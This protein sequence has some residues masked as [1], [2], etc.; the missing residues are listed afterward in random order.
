MKYKTC[1]LFNNTEKMLLP[2]RA[3]SAIYYASNKRDPQTIR[4]MVVMKDIVDGD[5]LMHS[6]Q[7]AM[8]RY[9][10]Y[11]IAVVEN[12]GR[13]INVKNNRP[14]VVKHTDKPAN[15]GSEEVNYHMIA[16]SYREKNIYL[17]ASHG[18]LDG[19]SM[20][21]VLKTVILLYCN[22]KYDVE[23]ST[24]GIL[25]ME[26]IIE[27]EEWQEPFT[28]DL[29]LPNDDIGDSNKAYQLPEVWKGNTTRISF[30]LPQEEFM[31]Y[32][33]QYHGTPGIVITNFF[34][35][36][37]MR[38]CDVQNL[39]IVTTMYVNSRPVIGKDKAGGCLV[40]SV[41]LPLTEEMKKLDLGKRVYEYRKM[42]NEKTSKEKILKKISR[43]VREYT[44]N[45][46][47]EGLQ[48]K[49]DKLGKA[50]S[51]FQVGTFS[52][53]ST[54]R[55]PFGE[56]SKFIREVH[57]IVIPTTYLIEMNCVN[58]MFTIDFLQSFSEA[59][60]VDEFE[61]I[62]KEEGIPYIRQKAE[63]YNTASAIYDKINDNVL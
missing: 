50:D 42:Q 49:L 58:H 21:E 28:D 62:L 15:L 48:E 61:K 54:G 4:I 8:E 55:D 31:N 25:T 44:N 60:Y 16:W 14:I 36:V 30:L 24:D 3:A 7:K 46:K 38:L 23:L 12:D 43:Q 1:K 18:L 27:D 6:V 22:E 17:D 45:D 63:N 52:V 29:I 57:N 32:V 51:V 9:P 41:E 26:N 20:L 53:S 40:T 39:P 33:K 10:Y 37:I 13:Y 5:M 11:H 35:E 34:S 47:L 59:R 19:I 2:N 56:V